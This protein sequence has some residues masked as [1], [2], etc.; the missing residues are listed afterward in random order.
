VENNLRRTGQMARECGL[1]VSALRFYDSAGVLVPCRVDPQTGY[2]W[3]SSEQ[4][5]QARLV[6]RLR[7]VG[8]PLAEIRRVLER[9]DDRP[10]AEQILTAHLSRLEAGLADARREFSAARAL[11]E[12]QENT[13]TQPHPCTSVT[14]TGQDLAAALLAVQYAVSEDPDLPMLGGV[15][16]D[17]DDDGLRVV[18]T[19][20]Y[21]LAVSAVPVSGR[22]GPAVN[23]IAAP[24]FVD[25]AIN[26]L[27]RE[28][29][30][31]TV[32]V[33]GDEIVLRTHARRLSGRRLDYDFPD[34]RRL[35]RSESTHSVP[36][37]VAALRRDVRAAATRTMQRDQDGVGYEVA[38][39][40][41]GTDGGVALTA[42]AT[43]PLQLG[44]NREYLLQALDATHSTELILELDGPIAPLA[45]R[46]PERAGTV[47]LLMPVRLP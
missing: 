18:A 11:L 24:A 46:D 38:V 29:A 36:V 26:V 15:A 47:S 8:M 1:T 42:D 40:T 2:R 34:Y 16:I 21:R 23:V 14:L 22:T 35:L 25:E 20:R 33:G 10:A 27:S 17:I 4:V 32:E 19:D 13:V 7:R 44:L 41:L 9:R 3:Y 6:A 37:D 31:V 39:L 5:R 45:I 28:P 12:P 43:G 30:P